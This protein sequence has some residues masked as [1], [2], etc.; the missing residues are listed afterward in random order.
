MKKYAGL[1]VLFLLLVGSSQAWAAGQTV[2]AYSPDFPVKVAGYS[3]QTGSDE[4]PLLVYKNI[5]YWPMTYDHG[6]ILGIESNWNQETGLVISPSA[7]VP[8]DQGGR[9]YQWPPL[10]ERQTYRAAI[11]TEPVTVFGQR[12][13]NSK[14]A[15]PLLSYQDVIY[16]PMTWHWLFDTFGCFYQY[17]GV[18]QLEGIP[19]DQGL[20][21]IAKVEMTEI[22]SG[23]Y[24]VRV[25]YDPSF[26]PLHQ[27][28]FVQNKG[29][30][31][32]PRGRLRDIYGYEVTKGQDGG[33]GIDVYGEWNKQT[34]ITLDGDWL[35]INSNTNRAPRVTSSTPCKINLL[36]NDIV[37]FNQDGSSM[38]GVYFDEQ[39]NLRQP[40]DDGSEDAYVL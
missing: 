24:T 9:M 17:N 39:G 40:T 4:Y 25:Y 29:G 7:N 10:E 27:N 31:F 28:V 21:V 37:Y 6:Q 11:V 20:V 19:L 13:D 35:Y 18:A 22:T 15:Y 33:H 36:T 1:L 32:Q 14:E 12:I 26:E 38:E 23:D 5:T 8:L 2:T 16:F 30:A 34:D 3:F